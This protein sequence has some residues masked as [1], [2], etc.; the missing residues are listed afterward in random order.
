VY[1][2]F[3]PPN[4][5]SGTALDAD[6]IREDGIEELVIVGFHIF[7][8]KSDHVQ[9]FDIERSTLEQRLQRKRVAFYSVFEVPA[10]LKACCILQ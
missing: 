6:K 8:Q 7:M 3:D 9:K 4:G 2:D 10:D 5:Y 1:L